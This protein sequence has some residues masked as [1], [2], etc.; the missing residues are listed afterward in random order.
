MNPSCTTCAHHKIFQGS[1]CTRDMT[2]ADGR[3]LSQRNTGH[4]IEHERDEKLTIWRKGNL[5]RK[6]G[7]VCGKDAKHW[8]GRTK[9]I[10]G[11]LT[12]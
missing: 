1:K 7:D 8:Q 10:Q 2:L 11:D 12:Q 3:I 4:M 9:I 6:G 5:T